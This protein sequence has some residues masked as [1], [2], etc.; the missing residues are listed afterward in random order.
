MVLRNAQLNHYYLVEGD[1]DPSGN[2]P[3]LNPHTSGKKK[4][5]KR[6]TAGPFPAVVLFGRG[7]GH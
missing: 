3:G 6:V 2:P 7:A 4:Y 5:D 1:P